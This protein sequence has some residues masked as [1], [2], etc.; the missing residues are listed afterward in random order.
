MGKFRARHC[1]RCSYYLGFSIVK[2]PFKSK[3][4][5]VTSFCLNC[6]YKLPIRAIIRG[7]RRTS[8]PLRRG[9]LR[10]ASM[11]K[12]EQTPVLETEQVNAAAENA[13]A[14][15]D[16]ARHLRV[17]GQDVE[18]LRL[19]TF[20]LEC[21]GDAYLVWS[22]PGGTGSED[23]PISRVSKNRL[24]KLWKNKS[25]PRSYGQEEL[26][27][28]PS[29]VQAKRYR[30]SLSDIDRMEHESRSRR[31]H[32]PGITD[33]HSLSQLLRTVGAIVGQRHERLLGISWQ[34]FS[35]SVVVETTQGQREIDVFR[36]DNLYDLW[37]R[38]Y[39]RRDNRAL[40]DFPR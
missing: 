21:T 30:Y 25:R 23:N 22:R 17:I 14:P 5:S 20:N 4:T 8:S 7:I 34:D 10:L 11:T 32:K 38:M 18:G 24:Q 15:L 13:L 36:P 9:A 28:L 37:V 35:V 3:E 6:N 27:T 16:Y 26:V 12:G 39:L 40:S 19:E 2:P 1:P 31:Y 33:G 29:S